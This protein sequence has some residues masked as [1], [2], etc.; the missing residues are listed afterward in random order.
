[1]KLV[2]ASLFLPVSFAVLRG[3]NN[4]E[5]RGLQQTI[6]K[7]NSASDHLESKFRSSS[8]LYRN[9]FIHSTYLKLTSYSSPL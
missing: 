1:M 9:L 8:L 5:R 6:G 3:G 7:Y 2:L 4:N